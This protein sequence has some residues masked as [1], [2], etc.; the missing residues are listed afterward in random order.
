MIF[1]LFLVFFIWNQCVCVSP[2]AQTQLHAMSGY[3]GWA[4]IIRR[5]S[6]CPIISRD[7]QTKHTIDY[8]HFIIKP[9]ITW[10]G[11]K[12]RIKDEIKLQSIFFL[13]GQGVT[14]WDQRDV[15]VTTALPKTSRLSWAKCWQRKPELTQIG[16]LVLK[17]KTYREEILGWWHMT[18]HTVRLN[19]HEWN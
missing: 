11:E 5:P 3:W 6:F 4:L 2:C 16:S 18:T 7:S 13:G 19:T 17:L 12:G 1:T 10:K 9:I 8:L 15:T 14:E